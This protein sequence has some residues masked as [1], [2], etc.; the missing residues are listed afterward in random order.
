MTCMPTPIRCLPVLAVVVLACGGGG[1]GG[2]HASSSGAASAPSTA[3]SSNAGDAPVADALPPRPD[4]CAWLTR[5]EVAAI[6]GP[7][8]PTV[9]RV[10]ALSNPEPRDDGRACLYQTAPASAGAPSARIVVAVDPA[11]NTEVEDVGKILSARIAKD[12]PGTV[13]VDTTK[14]GHG[15]DASS[16]LIDTYHARLGSLAVDVATPDWG[17]V[18]L[19]RAR[20]ERLAAA[21]RDRVPDKPFAAERGG[22][23]PDGD[24]CAL[25]TA[26]EVEAIAGGTL[27]RAPFRSFE[28][29]PLAAEGG[30]GCTFWLGRHRALSISAEWSNGKELFQAATMM[31]NIMNGKLGLS[32]SSADTLDGDW[33]QVASA[34]AGLVFL[35]GDRMLTVSALTAHLDV[36]ATVQ[37]AAKAMGRLAKQ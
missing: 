28:S 11:G 35:R 12:A 30:A 2:S 19:E 1:E 32:G 4:P 18:K 3:A 21:V 29:G 14:A 22:Q 23:S 24:P 9:Q 16:W 26:A 36:A 25:V 6:I 31:G 15:W 7:L 10:F 20:I 13:T 8:Q 37:V 17:A 34:G 5:D 27:A 33:D